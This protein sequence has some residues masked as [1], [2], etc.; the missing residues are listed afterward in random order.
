MMKRDSVQASKFA[1]QRAH[2]E[3]GGVHV[4]AELAVNCDLL[5]ESIYFP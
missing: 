2:L 3:D 1:S 5:L 4:P